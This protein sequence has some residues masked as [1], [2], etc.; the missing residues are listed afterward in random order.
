AIN[1]CYIF[2]I[3][4]LS[5]GGTG[6]SIVCGPDGRVLHQASTGEEMIPI[7]I[8][9]ERVHRSRENGILRLGQPLKSFR[10]RNVD[11]T[12][13]QKGQKTAYLESLGP[14]IKPTRQNMQQITEV[15][16]EEVLQSNGLEGK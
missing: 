10:D 6:R 4:G 5:D 16:Q 3:N 14:L 15:L 12:V 8:D 11:F 9:L 13:F 7:E 2:D 1:Q